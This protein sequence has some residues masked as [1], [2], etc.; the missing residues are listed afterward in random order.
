MTAVSPSVQSPLPLPASTAASAT[1][2]A[3]GVPLTPEFE[4][5]LGGT[6]PLFDNGTRSRVEEW[7]RAGPGWKDLTQLALNH[8]LSPLLYTRIH[9]LSPSL[10]REHLLTL[11]ADA[12][13]LTQRALIYTAEMKRLIPLFEANRISTLV[14]KGPPLARN[15]YGSLA[16]RTFVD[17]DIMVHPEDV[18]RAWA[19]LKAEEYTLSYKF[20]AAHLPAL[21]RSGNHLI[22]YGSENQ[23]LELHWA[24]FP[25]SRATPFDTTGAWER[26]EPLRFDDMTIMTL[27]PH[28]LVHFLCL[29]GT[30]H[31]WCRLAWITDLAWF[32]FRYPEFDW[33]ALLDHAARLGTA[34]MTLVG[35]SLVH[36]LY[37][38]A[39]TARVTRQIRDDLEVLPLA[40]WMCQRLLTGVQ[41]LPTGL[42]LV[43]LVLRARERRRDRGRDLYHHL[44]ALRPNNLEQAPPAASILHTYT[45]H[46]FWYLL[47]KYSR[48]RD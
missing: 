4:L 10:P 27:A 13:T 21:I 32:I 20:S 44:M 8:S 46:R 31:A 47:L 40:R 34:H 43:R 17:L 3:F 12:V 5:L 35:L 6:S 28:D 36:E 25:K 24:F 38:C 19:L 42:E 33:D 45:L 41:D 37:G 39:L 29:H 22:L 18:E 2:N 7:L 1:A 15:L 16:L 23:C 30:K 9:L 14:F 48:A 11:K 26:R